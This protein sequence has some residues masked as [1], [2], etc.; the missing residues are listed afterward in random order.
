L[1]SFLEIIEEA[2]AMP[3]ME[4]PDLAANKAICRFLCEDF[5]RALNAIEMAEQMAG[6]PG[7]E[8]AG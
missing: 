6:N 3:E 2:I 4:K 1:L 8:S 5:K 7:E